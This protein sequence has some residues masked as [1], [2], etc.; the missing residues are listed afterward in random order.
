MQGQGTTADP[1]PAMPSYPARPPYLQ[2]WPGQGVYP[3]SAGTSMDPAHLQFL[4]QAFQQSQMHGQAAIM[5][6]LGNHLRT[7]NSG[8]I[9]MDYPMPNVLPRNA[10]IPGLSSENHNSV[11][12]RSRM[13]GSFG[14]DGS[15]GTSGGNGYPTPTGAS[16][17]TQQLHPSINPFNSSEAPYY[18]NPGA[19]GWPAWTG[20]G[21]LSPFPFPLN[22]V[23]H[24][25]SEPRTPVAQVVRQ[26][27]AGMSEQLGNAVVNNGE[28]K[29][30]AQRRI[31]RE[32]HRAFK[33]A[34]QE[35]P[36]KIQATEKGEVPLEFRSAVHT[37]FR[38]TARRWLNLSVIKFR[39]HPDSDIKLLKDDLDRRF[40]F[41]PPL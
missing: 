21:P 4:Y 1:M 12:A 28:S 35:W 18:F 25:V 10:P 36:M 19:S 16:A 37:Q 39:D 30:T 32:R 24:T 23:N 15:T 17:T 11:P 6:S 20:A 27:E 3:T 8:V 2:Q 13:S 33:I 22:N 26:G 9:N 38:A 7:I 40:L 34:S 41:D 5:G 14:R 31:Q 29:K